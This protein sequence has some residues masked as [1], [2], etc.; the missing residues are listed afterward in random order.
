MGANQRIY[1]KGLLLESKP[2]GP[3]RPP[4]SRTGTVSI[5]Y[6][7]FHAEWIFCPIEGYFANGFCCSI[8]NAAGWR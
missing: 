1:T 4:N 5:V 8:S 6:S 7:L 3:K 2:P